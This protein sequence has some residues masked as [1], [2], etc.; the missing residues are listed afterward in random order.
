MGTHRVHNYMNSWLGEPSSS[1]QNSWKRYNTLI[2]KRNEKQLIGIFLHPNFYAIFFQTQEVDRKQKALTDMSKYLLAIL[3]D[4]FDNFNDF[5]V[6]FE[7]V[8]QMKNSLCKMLL[9]LFLV[10]VTK[11]H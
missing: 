9:H 7:S 4:Y 11:N 10:V 1:F 8:F 2:N 3:N 6:N 5:L